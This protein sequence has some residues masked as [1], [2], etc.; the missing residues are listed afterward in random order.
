MVRESPRAGLRE[1]NAGNEHV[2]KTQPRALATTGLSAPTRERHVVR[3]T[4][5]CRLSERAA[6]PRL[7]SNLAAERPTTTTTAA[8]AA[9]TSAASEPPAAAAAVARHL[10]EPGVDLLLGLRKDIDEIPGLL[11]VCGTWLALRVHEKKRAASDLLSVVK[12]VMAVPLAPARPVR[13]ILWM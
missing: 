13:P 8:T 10:G 5:C 3:A 7:C 2:R 12:N 11:G 4:G 1:N 6:S 9:V